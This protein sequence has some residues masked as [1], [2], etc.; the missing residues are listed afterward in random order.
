MVTKTGECIRRRVASGSQRVSAALVLL[1]IWTAFFGA[2]TM[3][4][5]EDWKSERLL[6][7]SALR[8]CP[9]GIKTLNNLAASMLNMDEAGRAEELLTRAIEVRMTTAGRK[10]AVVRDGKKGAPPATTVPKITTN[11][12]S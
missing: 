8:V 5:C 4:R 11:F 3:R 9:D 12:V 10:A 1:M 2:R 6:F 7:E